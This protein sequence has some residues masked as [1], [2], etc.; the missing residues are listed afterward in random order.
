MK[1]ILKAV[2][3]YLTTNKKARAAEYALLLG[4]VEAI[5]TA[6]GHA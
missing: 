1:A 3:T 6:T 5:R 4:L 2:V